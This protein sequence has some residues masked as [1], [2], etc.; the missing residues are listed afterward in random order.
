MVYG[1]LGEADGLVLGRDSREQIVVAVI[2]IGFDLAEG[3]GG[4]QQ[5]VAAIVGKGG[6][7]PWIHTDKCD[8]TRFDQ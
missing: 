2:G 8:A 4:A 7:E 1:V 6:A 3:I 5:P